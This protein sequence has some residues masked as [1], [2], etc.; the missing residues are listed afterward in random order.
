MTAYVLNRGEFSS[1][2]VDAPD[3]AAKIFQPL[4]S[5]KTKGTGL[6]LAIVQKSVEQHGGSIRV[7]RHAGARHASAA[8]AMRAEALR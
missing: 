1:L 5:T 2:L 3:V 4:F 6:G 7:A 8:R